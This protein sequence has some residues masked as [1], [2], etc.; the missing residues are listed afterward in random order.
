LRT[1]SEEQAVPYDDHGVAPVPP[2]GTMEAGVTIAR[3]DGD[4]ATAQAV[5]AFASR[6]GMAVARRR[7]LEAAVTE[8]VALCAAELRL[9]AATD[10]RWVSVRV[11][12]AGPWDPDRADARL[13][14]AVREIAERLELAPSTGGAGTSVLMEIP[15]AG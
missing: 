7:R 8:A 15:M 10:R 14:P 4:A 5:G 6:H 1:G 12:G 13:G 11:D 3:W 2:Q 9:E